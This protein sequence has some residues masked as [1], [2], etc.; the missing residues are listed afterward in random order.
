[1]RFIKKNPNISPKLSL[2]LLDWSVRESF[3]LLH[4]LSKQ[5]IVRDS[6]EVILIEY[7]STLSE[8][9]QKFSE[10]IDTWI[11]L[12]MPA[13]CYYHKHLMYNVGIVFSQGEI[14]VICDSDAMVKPD[15]I[16]TILQEFARPEKIVLHLD[17]FRNNRQDFYPFNYP[18]FDQVI[19]EGCSNYADGRTTGITEVF[20]PLHKRNYGACMCAR[21]A[22]LIAIGGADEHMDYVGYI[23]GP[24][25]ITFRLIN[26]G[27]KEIWHENEF[28]Y[29]TW[30]P[31]QAG[32]DNYLGPHD[33][34]NMSTTALAA[35]INQRIFPLVENE[36]I[37]QLRLND[38]TDRASEAG[39]LINNDYLHSISKEQLENLPKNN[40][41]L[42]K[43]NIKDFTAR[44]PRKKIIYLVINLYAIM[45]KYFALFSKGFRFLKKIITRSHNQHLA[46]KSLKAKLQYH[47]Q[48]ENFLLALLFNSIDNLLLFFDDHAAEKNPILLVHEL[49]KIDYLNLLIRLNLLPAV[50]IISFNDKNSTDS[51]LQNALNN[52]SSKILVSSWLYLIFY[53]QFAPNRKDNMVII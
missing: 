48:N 10:Q 50:T 20:D 33:G 24:Y 31:G 9:A 49:E 28:M 18:T 46:N 34:R 23:C 41:A 26:A 5:N 29:H 44:S 14:C 3:H 38:N 37:K 42:F 11:V 47:S 6:F 39:T 35:L 51:Y 4:Y 21:R 36:A 27:A 19:G 16:N 53:S 30:H 17:Q 40:N 43:F 7:Y 8:A 45:T 15:F 2:I 22:D 13:K 52:N 12:D 1:M 32:D 25:E